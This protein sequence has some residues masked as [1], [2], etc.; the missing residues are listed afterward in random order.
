MAIGDVK[1]RIVRSDGQELTLGDGDWRIPKD[2]LEN[3]A[4]LPYS[5]NSTEIPMQNGGIVTS[6][7]VSS[8]DRTVTAEC[9]GK[10]PDALRARAIEF[11]NPTYSFEAHMTYRGRTRWCGGEQIGF[12][13]SEGNIYRKPVITWTM[14]CTNPFM[15]SEEDFG[16]DIADI[17]PLFGFPFVSFL[18]ESDGSIPGFPTGFA[19]SIHAFSQNVIVRNDGDVPSSMRAIIRAKDHVVNPSLRLGDGFVR[20]LTE[21][22]EGDEIELDSSKRPPTVTMNGNDAMNKLDR[23]SSILALRV[24]VGE[25][26][27]EYDADDGYANMSVTVFWNKQYL[28][29]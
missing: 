4:N 26:D 9:C 7:R 17:V 2:G 13:A 24:G 15:Q 21:M 20:I 10:D 3:W 6:K 11:F 22:Y 16:K 25:T 12:K 19:V 23:E 8:V 5:V 28:G 1:V 29:V 18:P 14:L 27:L